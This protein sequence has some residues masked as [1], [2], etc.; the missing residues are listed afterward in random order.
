MA[1]IQK[2]VQ[3]PADWRVARPVAT[4]ARPQPGLHELGAMLGA[5][6]GQVDAGSLEA[7]LTETGARALRITPWRLF[8]LEG[9]PMP[10]ES[11]FVT[12]PG[13]PL[14]ST[15]AC[16][17]M[18]RCSSATVETRE[19]ALSLAA[20]FADGLHV[21]GCSKG[22]ARARPSPVTLVGREGRFDLIRDGCAWDPPVQTDLAPEDVMAGVT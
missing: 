6:F 9:V 12:R 7:A 3:V 19:L 1:Q 11:D 17:G 18:P 8:L 21:S 16:P 15:D 5:P 4:A 14:L 20:R 22:C 10:T 2:G 13:D